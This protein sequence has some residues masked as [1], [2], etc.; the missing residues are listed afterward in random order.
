MVKDRPEK[1]GNQVSAFEVIAIPRVRNQNLEFIKKTTAN[2]GEDMG[3]R[4]PYT[5]LIVI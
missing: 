5:L 1:T 2:A 4:K 3:K